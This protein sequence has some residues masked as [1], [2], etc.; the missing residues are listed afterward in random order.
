MR[1]R[2]FIAGLGSAAAWPVVAR[3]QLGSIPVIGFLNPRSAGEAA[4]LAVAFLQG[5]NTQ[6]FVEGRNVVI[7]Y[8]WADGQY[9]RLRAMA[10]DLAHYR[11]TVI[12]ATGGIPSALAAKEATSTIPIVFSMDGDPVANEFCRCLS[13]SGGLHWS[14]AQGCEGR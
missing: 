7:E 11:V 5:L 14:S 10:A 6:G 4:H 12:A 13:S 1:R 2:Q 8:R 9:D 3:A